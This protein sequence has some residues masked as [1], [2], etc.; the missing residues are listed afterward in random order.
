MGGAGSM[1]ASLLEAAS[2]S[3][4]V[5]YAPWFPISFSTVA[6]TWIGCCAGTPSLQICVSLPSMPTLLSMPTDA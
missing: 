2:S 3:C 5:S 1:K 4:S 6:D